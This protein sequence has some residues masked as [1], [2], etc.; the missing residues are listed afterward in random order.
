MKSSHPAPTDNYSSAKD[1]ENAI[2]ETYIQDRGLGM[3]L[4]PLT[5]ESAARECNCHPSELCHGALAG[6]LE[7][8][9]RQTM[10]HT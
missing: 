6:K 4:A 2:E 10:H 7:G 5:E 1:H 3:A 8:L 9:Q